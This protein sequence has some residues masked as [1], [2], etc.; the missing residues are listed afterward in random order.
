MS[1][2]LVTLALIVL[3]VSFTTGCKSGPQANFTAEPLTG[4]P[5]LEVQF[6]DISTGEAQAWE[7]DF[8]G[9]GIIDSTEQNPQYTYNEPGNYTV[10]LTASN[11]N[12]NNT[13]IQTEYVKVTTCPRYADF[14]AEPTVG[15]GTTTVQFT[16]MSMGEVLSWAW[17]FQ[18]DGII[19]SN[20]QNPSHVYS[21]NGVYSV[22]LTITTTAICE[23]TITK[24]D[25][26]SITGCH[27]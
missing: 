25:Y 20:E 21:K 16:D 22:T 15:V 12:G 7:W 6:T 23:D 24:H 8:N 13:L 3:L 19:D 10:S 14:I 26:I 18:S 1:K 9:D 17:D 2:I 27:T 11:P 5:P 4:Y